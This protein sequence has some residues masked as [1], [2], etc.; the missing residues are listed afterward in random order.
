M[1][2]W[3]NNKLNV[4]YSV[5]GVVYILFIQYYGL[6]EHVHIQ[7]RST[8]YRVILKS[9]HF[10]DYKDFYEVYIVHDKKNHP[11]CIS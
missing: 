8:L 2:V 3:P 9:Q 5:V 7:H 11:R 10:D 1:S 6:P 4:I